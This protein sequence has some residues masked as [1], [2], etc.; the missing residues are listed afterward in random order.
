MRRTVQCSINTADEQLLPARL[1]PVYRALDAAF[2]TQVAMDTV[3]YMDRFWRLAGNPGFNKSQDFIRASLKDAGIAARL[4]DFPNSGQGWEPISL[5]LAIR[6][7]TSMEGGT[8]ITDTTLVGPGLGQDTYRVSTAINSFSTGGE[9]VL[10]FVD[11][12]EGTS[13]SDYE[14]KTVKGAVVLASASARTVWDQAV[15]KRGAAGIIS[16]YAPSYNVPTAISWESIPYDPNRRA[17]ALKLPPQSAERLKQQAA[18]GYQVIVDIKTRFH[19][20]PNRNLIAEIP[21]LTRADERIVMV[22]HVQEPGANDDASGCGTL[23]ALARALQKG[24]K[25]GRIPPPGRTLTFLW[26]DEIRG[27]Q[28]WLEENPVRAANVQYM[29]SLDMVG[30]NT[31]KTGGTF[32]IEKQ[33][34]PSAVWERPSDPHSEWGASDVKAESLKGSLLN[35]LHLAVCRRR[36]R[37]TGWIVRTNPYEGGSDHTVFGRAGIPSVLNW[38]FTDRYYHTNM[39]RPDKVS[40][41]EMKNVGVSVATSAWMLA[42]ANEEDARAVR[43]LIEHAAADR[44]KV[45]QQNADELARRGRTDAATEKAVVA[46]W[47]SGT[48]RR[49]K[50]WIGWQ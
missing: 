22:A 46:A 4:E 44:R 21:G 5:K 11:V 40:P 27:S 37:D 3:L 2:E 45:E 10:P 32:L 18:N 14:G 43:R 35:D 42:S 47:E 36:A 17:F 13:D 28:Q 39:D 34:D 23:L 12:G 16:Y 49:W 41:Q 25:S 7:L 26:V 24:I 6:K 29:F 50:A 20:G 38:H 8:R 30:E 15:S 9:V 19:R 1:E 31:A 33:P 48:G